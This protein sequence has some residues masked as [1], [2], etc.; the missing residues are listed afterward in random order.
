MVA[1][2]E[3]AWAAIRDWGVTGMGRGRLNG[4]ES[5]PDQLGDA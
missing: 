2:E 1:T 3:G 5:G 4:Q